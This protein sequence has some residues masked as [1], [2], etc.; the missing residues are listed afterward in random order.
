MNFKRKNYCEDCGIPIDDDAFFCINC[1]HKTFTAKQLKRLTD[2][3]FEQCL[4]SKVRSEF[5][6]S[7]T[8]IKNAFITGYIWAGIALLVVLFT[9]QYTSLVDVALV[10]ILS[11]GLQKKNRVCAILLSIDFVYMVISRIYSSTN[12]SGWWV[13]FIVAFYL[14]LGLKGTFDYWKIRR[15][16]VSAG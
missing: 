12:F 10:A 3:E 5:M 14:W 4:T 6:E 2:D 8:N 11:L 13:W 7:K 15:N 16:I 1:G 9:S